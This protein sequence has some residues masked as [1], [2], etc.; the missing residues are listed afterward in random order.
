MSPIRQEI[1]NVRNRLR[2]R[3]RKRLAAK[4]PVIDPTKRDVWSIALYAG[5]SPFDL[6]PIEGLERPVMTAKDVSDVAADFVADP[7]MVRNGDMWHMF[8]EVLNGDLKKGQIAV[9][10]SSNGYDWEYQKIVLDEPFHLSYPHVFSWKN[11]YYMIPESHQAKA[12][13]LYRAVEFPY[14]WELVK[15]LV[16]DVEF[17]DTSPFFHDNRWWFFAGAG[18]GWHSQELRLFHADDLLGPWVEHPKSPVVK[19]NSHIARPSGRVLTM[20]GKIYRLTQDC[21]PLYGVRVRAFEVTKLTELHYQERA[22]KGGPILN[23]SG[24]GWNAVGMHHMDAHLMADGRWLASVDGWTWGD[25]E[26]NLD[27]VGESSRKGHS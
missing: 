22:V 11:E 4:L 7:F 23:P 10:N 3:W 6:R 15:N 1:R 24:E 13:R 12:V 17:A 8:F 20:G 2:Q 21:D 9:A 14:R 16:E 19:G 25:V 26:V 27:Q 18:E 5:S